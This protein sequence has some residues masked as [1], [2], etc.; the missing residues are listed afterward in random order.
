MELRFWSGPKI[1]K[2]EEKNIFP[3]TPKNNEI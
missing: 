1:K 3:H 2:E